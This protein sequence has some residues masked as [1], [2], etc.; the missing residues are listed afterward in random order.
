MSQSILGIGDLGA[1]NVAGAEIKTFALGSCVAVVLLDPRTRTVGMVHI[2]LPESS[3]NPQR[4][5]ERPGYFADLA[6]PALLQEMSK[7]GCNPKGTGLFVKLAGG[8]S[9]M[10][11]NEAFNIGKRNIAAVKE[12][13]SQMGLHLVGEDV[14]G[15]ISRTVS[16]SVS[17]GKVTI[18]SPGRPNWHI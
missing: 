1:T 5:R 12:L 3:I 17:T 10:A 15:T 7:L 8:A 2:A 11:Q 9:I 13:I 18:S 6:L 16:I 14:G 4:G